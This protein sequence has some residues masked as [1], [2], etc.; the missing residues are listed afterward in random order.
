MLF[1]PIFTK[2]LT[3][4]IAL[5]MYALALFTRRLNT[6]LIVL[7]FLFFCVGAPLGYDTLMYSFIISSG[8]LN[9]YGPLWSAIGFAANWVDVWWLVNLITYILIMYAFMV[10][11]RLS[12]WPSLL[13]AALVTMPGLG[14]D[15]LSVMRQGLSTAFVILFY[16]AL[17]DSRAIKSLTFATLAFFAHPAGLFAVVLLLLVRYKDNITRIGKYIAIALVVIFAISAILPDYFETQVNNI[18]F[19]FAR[20]LILDSAIENAAGR[21]LFLAWCAILTT[22][23]IIAALYRRIN[24][25]SKEMYTVVLFL[26]AYGLLLAVSGSSVRLLWFFLPMVM[27]TVV[28]TLANR[29]RQRVTLLPTSIF[30]AVICFAASAYV[31]SIAPEHFWTGEYPHEIHL[32][33]R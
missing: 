9:H 29:S 4:T 16:V 22:P 12:V 25:L 6:G 32:I 3:I 24:W 11:A 14:F 21:K 5:T 7:G 28:S 30:F 19:L 17:K 8:G 15:L 31:L 20:Y 27:A 18:T 13:L 2:V 33:E 26:A 1:D 10:L 23:L